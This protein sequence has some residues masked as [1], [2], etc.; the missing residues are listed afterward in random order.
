MT[1]DLHALLADLHAQ[2]RRVEQLLDADDAAE[3]ARKKA[4]EGPPAGFPQPPSYAGSGQRCR[5]P[6]APPPAGG[7]DADKAAFWERRFAATSRNRRDQA[8]RG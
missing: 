3:D 4:L 7:S 5:P 2:R 8:G 1:D 6:T